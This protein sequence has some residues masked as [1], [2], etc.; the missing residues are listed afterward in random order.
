[1][2]HTLTYS[3]HEVAPYIH[4]SYFFHA[5][6]LPARVA[7]I[8]T[9]HGCDSCRALWLASFPVGERQQAAEA[10]QLYKEACRMLDSW[11]HDFKVYTRFGLFKAHAEG[12][13]L[14]LHRDMPDHPLLRIPLLRQQQQGSGFRCLADF[15][16]PATGGETDTV[17]VFAGTADPGM[18]HLYEEGPH[19]DPYKHLLAQTLA[20]R[21]VEAAV[22][23]MHEAVRKTYWG[24][25]PHEQLTIDE[26]LQHCYQGI[27][28]AVGYPSLPDQS[29]N[30]ILSELL[31][32][33]ELGITL[34]ENGA[35]QP[36]ASVSG[37]ML[38]HPDAHY[39][40]IGKIG[41]DQWLD[42]ARRRG[43]EPDET[44][45]FLTANLL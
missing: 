35:M 26:L 39:F 31:H 10:M 18:E 40:S 32:F 16:R 6:N 25:A 38:S 24:Y 33:E 36:H 28:P 17:G 4:W 12:D 29:V 37:L 15:I 5:W 23:R 20:D 42:Y 22:E 30:F 7:S 1:M 44:A 45:R 13:D 11:D 27:R 41:E 3:L 9:L 14:M 43:M 21:L 34:T 8:S 19:A 2:I